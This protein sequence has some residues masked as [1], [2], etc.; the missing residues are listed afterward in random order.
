MFL[1]LFLYFYPETLK[2][3]TVMGRCFGWVTVLLFLVGG[4][5]Q[6]WGEDKLH[7][8]I[9][10]LPPLYEVEEDG[11]PNGIL[12]A[13]LTRILDAAG[14]SYDIRVY[15]PRRLYWNIAQGRCHVFLGVKGVPELEG[16]V[17]YGSKKITDV[18]MR[19]YALGDKPLPRTKEGLY[20]TRII[21]IRGYSY[22]GF[23]TDLKNPA[24]G[25]EI[26]EA[27]DHIHAFRQLMAGRGEYV[28]DYSLAAEHAIRTLEMVEKV[29]D[30]SLARIDVFLK[31]SKQV[32]N[33]EHIM[34]RLEAAWERLEA[35]AVIEGP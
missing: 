20:G 11:K 31:V 16:K 28:L 33:A 35:D 6:S 2:V 3:R 25:V 19:A 12:L 14:F 5:L 10:D 23:I 30:Q 8:G 4:S 24:N 26:M 17:L 22:G 7:V 32:D 13:F 29:R 9:L 1:A 15:P 21:V 18:D 27:S 34:E